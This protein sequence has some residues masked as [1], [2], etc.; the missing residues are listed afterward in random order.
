[1]KEVKMSKQSAV[2]LLEQQ[3]KERYSLMNS[4]P[5][6]EQAKEMEKEQ[7]KEEYLKG[8]KSLVL[9]IKKYE[10]TYPNETCGGNN[11]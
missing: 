9:H 5:L 3:L 6:F 2:E 11:E 1:M 10:P 7:K 4:E 8:I